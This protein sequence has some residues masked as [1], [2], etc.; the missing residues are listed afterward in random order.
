MRDSLRLLNGPQTLGRGRLFWG[1]FVLIVGGAAI[2]PMFSDSYTVGNLAYFLVWTFMALGLSLIWGYTG[3]FSFGQTAFFGLAGYAYGVITINYGFEHGLTLAALLAALLLAAIFAALLG[4]FMFYGGVTDVFVG[5]ITLATTLVLETFLAQT[6]GP[7]WTIGRARLNGF[8]GMTGMP[9]LTIPWFG[10]ENIFL[11]GTSLY[12]ALLVLLLLVYLGLRMLVNSRFGNVLVAIRENPV[13]AEMLGYDVRRYQL[14]AF[15]LGSTLAGL[16]GVTYTA[17]GQYITPE[18]MGLNVAA[19]P[20]IWVAA[21]GRKD[22]TA[23]LIA[24][25]VLLYVSQSLNVYGSQ[26]ALVLLGGVLLVAVIFAPEGFVVTLAK[27][28]GRWFAP[29]SPTAAG[30]QAPGD[31]GRPISQRQG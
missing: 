17:W 24:T 29:K 14:I 1:A 30:S 15:V 8:N 2:F 25:L 27:F 26:Y 9:P 18:S 28:V 31:D 21:G 7:E 5:I 20:V 6:A 13:R 4:Y 11:E 12:Y 22:L 19:L 23:T 16:S 10:D 3:I